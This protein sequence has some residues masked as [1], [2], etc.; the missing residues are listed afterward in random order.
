MNNFLYDATVAELAI[1]DLRQ[2]MYK[3]KMYLSYVF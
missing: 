1:G 2:K 3:G